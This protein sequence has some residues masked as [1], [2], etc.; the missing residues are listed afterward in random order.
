MD[1]GR[2]GPDALPLPVALFVGVGMPVVPEAHMA[3][4]DDNVES[5]PVTH[6]RHVAV[7]AHIYRGVRLPHLV[8]DLTRGDPTEILL[9]RPDPS[10]GIGELEAVGSAPVFGL[11]IPLY[12]RT[13]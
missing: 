6:E 5:G 9:L 1:L 13:Y 11:Y 3:P 8:I 12:P 2:V 10:R 7:E 4:G